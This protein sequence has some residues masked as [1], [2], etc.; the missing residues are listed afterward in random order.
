VN[1][2]CFDQVI[3]KALAPKLLSTNRAARI[4]SLENTDSQ[5]SLAFQHAQIVP[6][7]SLFVYV[8]VIGSALGGTE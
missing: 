2:K 3:R 4:P 5:R 6:Q 7:N 1:G 8:N